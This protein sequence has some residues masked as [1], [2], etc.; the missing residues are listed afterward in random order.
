MNDPFAALN[1]P[2]QF[3]LDDAT[4]AAAQR[5]GNTPAYQIIADPRQRAD[6]LLTLLHGPTKEMWSGLPTDFPAALAAAGSDAGKLAALREDRLK[7]ISNLFRQLGSNDKATVQ[8]G[9]QRMVRAQLNA[10]DQLGTS[11]PQS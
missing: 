5:A 8:M 11:A 1:I 7:R 6:T 10:L 2:R 9:R 3:D 4:L